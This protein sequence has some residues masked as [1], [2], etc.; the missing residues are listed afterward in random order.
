MPTRPQRNSEVK[1]C[2][3][4][5]STGARLLLVAS[6]STVRRGTVHGQSR[7][8]FGTLNELRSIL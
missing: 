5:H 1:C 8:L 2:N 6:H 3:C 4:E 7:E